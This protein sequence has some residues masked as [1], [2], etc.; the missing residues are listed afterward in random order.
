M[1][2]E[3]RISA[4]EAQRRFNVSEKTIR[5]WIKSGRLS[6]KDII[7]SG[8]RQHGILPSDIQLLLEERGMRRKTPEPSGNQEHRI[9]QLEE[10]VEKLE[11]ALKSIVRPVGPPID[12]KISTSPSPPQQKRPITVSG[13]KS[14][15]PEG[16]AIFA[17][18]FDL[19]GIS[20]S[21]ARRGMKNKLFKVEHGVW[22]NAQG[23]RVEQLLDQQGQ[24]EFHL[25]YKIPDPCPFCAQ[26]DTSMP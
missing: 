26:T 21:T 25:A 22:Y 17:E 24:Q 10:R 2:E 20:E 5:N 13:S 11:I 19:H 6:T 4:I 3:E 18:F 8:R 12:F 15:I 9:A 1:A 7:I 14:T 16:H 23:K